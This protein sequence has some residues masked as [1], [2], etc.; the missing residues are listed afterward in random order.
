MLYCIALLARVLF[1]IKIIILYRAGLFY[2]WRKPDYPEKT[3]VLSQV[4]D[5][6]YHYNTSPIK[7]SR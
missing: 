3:I 5:T 2:W 4:T 7:E 1:A 6:L